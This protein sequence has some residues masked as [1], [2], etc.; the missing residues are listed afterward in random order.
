MVGAMR[1]KMEKRQEV[2]PFE[3][4]SKKAARLKMEENIKSMD[5]F[6]RE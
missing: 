5:G 2:I 4:A 3:M 1:R 6:F